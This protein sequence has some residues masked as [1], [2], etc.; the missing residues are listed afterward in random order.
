LAFLLRIRNSKYCH[1]CERTPSGK[2][3]RNSEAKIQFKQNK[4]CPST[5]STQGGYNGYVIDQVK[6]L[7][8]GGDDTPS[9]MQ[10]QTKEQAKQKD[11]WE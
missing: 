2:I 8:R 11:K 5:C 3:K 10:W 1:T 7:K 4:P 9:N 6:P